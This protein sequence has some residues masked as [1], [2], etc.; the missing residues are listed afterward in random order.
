VNSN[1][2]VSTEI[3]PDLAHARRPLIEQ[4]RKDGNLEDDG[5]F[6]RLMMAGEERGFVT[7]YRKYQAQVYRFSLQIGGIRHIAEEVTQETFLALM[8]APH[9][10]QGERGP[11]LLYLFGIARNLVWKSARKDRLYAALD[12]ELPAS[13]PDLA[14]DLARKQQAM[15]VRHAILSLPRRYREVIVLCSLQEL[16]YEQAA[17]VVGSSIGTLRSRVHRAKQLLLRKLEGEIA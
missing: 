5:Q 6:L 12:R 13:L 17:T 9:K 2:P 7:L 15:R 11:L 16:S 10:Y 14:N 1:C 3:T 8:K 4:R